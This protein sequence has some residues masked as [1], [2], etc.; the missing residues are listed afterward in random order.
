MAVPTPLLPRLPRASYICVQRRS[1]A[2]GEQRHFEQSAL[3]PHEKDNPH[4]KEK[5]IQ[6]D[7][8]ESSVKRF[9]E[10][11]RVL[12]SA[13]HLW[14]T[15]QNACLRR[16]PK[17]RSNYS[18]QQQPSKRRCPL[19]GLFPPARLLPPMSLRFPRGFSSRAPEGDPMSWAF[20]L[21]FLDG[22]CLC[23][24]GMTGMNECGTRHVFL[25]HSRVPSH[26]A[27]RETGRKAGSIRT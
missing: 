22:S 21:S 10:R 25:V 15:C 6:G 16:A 2:D 24:D 27:S 13:R 23:H 12:T 19:V 1:C 5:G 20:A 14:T 4:R 9:P 11:R 7:R 3:L 8:H 18:K 26:G 17:T